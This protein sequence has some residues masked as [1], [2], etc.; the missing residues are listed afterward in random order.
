MSKIRLDFVTNSSSSSFV[1]DV[2]GRQESGWDMCLSEADMYECENGHTICEDEMINDLTIEDYKDYLISQNYNVENIDEDDLEGEAMDY[3]FR[4]SLPEKHCPICNFLNYSQD[5]MSLYLQKK[6][7]VSRAEV[8]EEVKKVNKRRKKLYEGE[9][10]N[11]V[12]K[13]FNLVDTNIIETIKE[14]F[15]TYSKFGE[16]LRN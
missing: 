16:Y 15:G 13:K 14:E 1:C 11:Y 8:F 6:Y 12:C 3:D 10:I 9:Y 7:G 2:C 5:D 4:Y